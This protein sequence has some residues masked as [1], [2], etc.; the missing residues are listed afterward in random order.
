MI[1]DSGTPCLEPPE[2]ICFASCPFGHVREF[3]LGSIG[4][5]GL[6]MDRALLDPGQQVVELRAAQI[7][8]FSFRKNG[9]NLCGI[10]TTL[11]PSGISI[12]WS[13]SRSVTTQPCTSQL[14]RS[15][16]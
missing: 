16:L 11:S 5:P 10:S 14:P 8:A 6:Q 7:H 2:I 9:T 1:S 12:S 13:A 4:V 3:G 15:V